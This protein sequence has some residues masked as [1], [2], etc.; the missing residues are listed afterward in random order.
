M[1]LIICDPQYFSGENRMREGSVNNARG[2]SCDRRRY[3]RAHLFLFISRD[4]YRITVVLVRGTL[5][6]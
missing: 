6:C 5:G 3:Q 2:L 1:V 4:T